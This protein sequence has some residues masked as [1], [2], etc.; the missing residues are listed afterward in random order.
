M[1][2][3]HPLVAITPE[4]HWITRYFKNGTGLTSE[5]LV[6][7]KLV[8]KLCDY[9]RFASLSVSRKEL[10]KL[11]SS[12]EPVSY[13]RFVSYI[14]DRYAENQGKDLAGDKTP[15]Y[16]RDIHTLHHLW[17]QAKF[18]HII[19]D[20]R[21]V[22]LSVT[23]WRK[24]AKLARRFTVW[25]EDPITTSALWWEWHVRLGRQDGQELGPDL[26]HE[27]RYESLVGQPADE[28]AKLCE[29]LGLQYSDSMLRFHEG[30]ERTK[31]GLD[32]KHSWL[33]VT[34]GLRDWRSQLPAED[35][36]R[37]EAA[38]GDLL[39]ELGYGRGAYSPESDVMEHAARVHNGFI[40]DVRSRTDYRLPKGWSS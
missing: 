35:T 15:S 37:F 34:G 7:K 9:H 10:E 2:D 12:G 23:N 31:P 39:G 30:R 33:P 26:Y 28:C 24:S 20:G 38:A 22:C 3:E 6:T 17:P 1:V 29:F 27:I 21:D 32:A 5:S 8:L 14:F 25:E 11:I 4:T 16:V 19:R 13:S 18:V 40:R 36:E